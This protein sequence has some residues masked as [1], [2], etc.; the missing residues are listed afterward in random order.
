MT[1]SHKLEKYITK[2]YQ[3]Y[4]T[5]NLGYLILEL[6]KENNFCIMRQHGEIVLGK[7]PA[8]IKNTLNKFS[9]LALP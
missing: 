2:R 8:E 6:L 7:D 1:Y 9:K 4:G 3:K 5:F